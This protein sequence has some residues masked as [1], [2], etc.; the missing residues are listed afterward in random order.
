MKNFEEHIF[1]VIKLSYPITSSMIIVR[2]KD[3]DTLEKYLSRALKGA[4]ASPAAA[5][6]GAG[7]SIAME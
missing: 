3:M 1:F 6:P 5:G 2:M 7:Q 4:A